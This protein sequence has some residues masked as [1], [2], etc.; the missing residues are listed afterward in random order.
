MGPM[1]LVLGRCHFGN[2]CRH[3]HKTATNEQAKFI[4]EKLENIIKDPSGCKKGK[5][6]HS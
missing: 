2:E 3:H 1:Y 5:P 6:K 4:T